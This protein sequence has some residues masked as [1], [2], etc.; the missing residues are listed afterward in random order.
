MQFD[1][2]SNGPWTDGHGSCQEL[3]KHLR[4]R[5]EWNGMVPNV[6]WVW[7]LFFYSSWPDRHRSRWTVDGGWFHGVIAVV[8]RYSREEGLTDTVNHGDLMFKTT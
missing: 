6:R 2:W 1:W 7:C 8:A 4:G 3:N 5:G